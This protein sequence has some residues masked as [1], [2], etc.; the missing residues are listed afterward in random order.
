MAPAR[1]Q[2]RSGQGRHSHVFTHVREGDEAFVTLWPHRFDFIEAKHPNPGQKPN[3][4]TTSSHHLSDRKILE[5]KRLY[6]VRFGV[7]TRYIVI[8]I[9][10]GSPYHPA[11]DNF[12]LKRL[13]DALEPLGL[14]AHLTVCSS[15]SGG[16]H[17]YFPFEQPVPC[18]QIAAAVAHN[19]QN[20]GFK[21]RAGW[22]EILPDPKPF[23]SDGS[24]NLYQ[25]HRLPM[26]MGSY[27]LDEDL[28]PIG[29]SKTAFTHRWHRVTAKNSLDFT[30]V[31]Q[32]AKE[33]NTQTFR[34]SGKAR[35]YLNDLNEE[36][37][38]GWSQRGQTNSLLGLITRREY[39]FHHVTHGEQP[40]KGKALATAIAETA[41][42]LPGYQDWCGHQHEI[43]KRAEE[44]AHCIEGSSKYYPYGGKKLTTNQEDS[45]NPSP[46][47]N[48][49]QQE[50]ARNRIQAAVETLRQ[51]GQWVAL[52]IKQRVQAL[53]GYKISPQ[54][55]YRH[56][57]LWHPNSL[58]EPVEIPPSPP[59]TEKSFEFE[60]GFILG[61]NN[62]PNFLGQEAVTHE[63]TT[64]I[65]IAPLGIQQEGCNASG[66]LPAEQTNEHVDTTSDEESPGIGESQGVKDEE[67]S[68]DGLE[69]STQGFGYFQSVLAKLKKRQEKKKPDGGF[70]RVVWS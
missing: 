10:R 47:W 59:Q 16:L 38:K 56:K 44:W 33:V 58:I 35:Q 17:L 39:I 22:L 8:D 32:S 49:R 34:L 65:G 13:Q 12:A 53:R 54:T 40:L 18:W 19:L 42:S 52:G 64:A 5:G 11:Q 14:V 45:T 50:G 68:K 2:Q 51:L 28:L 30:A 48:Q 20:K 26:Q 25:A 61:S 46:T 24:I 21:T 66:Q 1:I 57:D 69:P 36:I 62:A 43:H 9:D 27:L 3:W 29:T 31:E 41:M 15:D 70:G 4:L 37:E 23:T 60:P 67:Q 6:G 63:E 7:E 55:L